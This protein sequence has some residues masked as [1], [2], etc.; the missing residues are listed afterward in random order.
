LQPT[1]TEKRI[2][3]KP[4]VDANSS[5]GGGSYDETVREKKAPMPEG[6]DNRSPSSANRNEVMTP[7]T[8]PLDEVLDMLGVRA[9]IKDQWRVTSVR[10]NSPSAK[11]GVKVGDLITALDD[12]D[13]NTRSDFINSGSVKM[14]TVKRDGKLISLKVTSH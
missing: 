5:R 8:I 2:S 12:K 1:D 3:V 11:S 6:L 4:R 14:I 7:T 9:N 10:E 13:I